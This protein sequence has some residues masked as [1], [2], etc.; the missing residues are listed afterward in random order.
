MARH[1]QYL[2]R[3]AY[4]R[5]PTKQCSRPS[6]LPLLTPLSLSGIRSSASRLCEL[7]YAQMRGYRAALERVL[8]RT[9]MDHRTAKEPRTASLRP[10][11]CARTSFGAPIT[12]S[13]VSKR[14]NV[15]GQKFDLLCIYAGV[16]V[17]AESESERS[18]DLEVNHHRKL[19]NARASARRP[20]CAVGCR[21]DLVIRREVTSRSRALGPVT[22]LPLEPHPAAPAGR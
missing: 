19:C 7:R 10:I 21:K 5:S 8:T 6:D 22:R 11:N 18:R 4:S 9:G 2:Q 13:V 16:R 3:V 12:F 14:R 20:H 17:G 15:L 1:G